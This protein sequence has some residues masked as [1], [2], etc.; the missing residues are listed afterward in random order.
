MQLIFAG[1]A[2]PLLFLAAMLV[3]LWLTRRRGVLSVPANA[4][5]VGSYRA[6]FTNPCGT[7]TTTSATLTVTAGAESKYRSGDSPDSDG[8]SWLCQETVQSNRENNA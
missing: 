3:Q 5:T 6:V 4:S 7:N 8:K 1:V 2:A